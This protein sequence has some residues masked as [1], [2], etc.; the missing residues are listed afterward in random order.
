MAMAAVR[1][2]AVREGLPVATEARPA[3]ATAAAAVRLEVSW[4][5]VGWEAAQ[6]APVCA[7]KEVALQVAMVGAMAMATEAERMDLAREEAIREE[8]L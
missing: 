6:E 5:M 4:A 2:V 8:A 7:G 3:A 1:A